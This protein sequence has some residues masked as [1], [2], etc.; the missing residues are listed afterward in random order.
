MADS[1]FDNRYR[2]D[3]IYPRGR[4][5]ETLRAVDTAQNDR[6]V[7]IKRPAPN[8]APPIRAGQEV[9]ILNERK[10]LLRLAGHA[11]LTAFIDAGQF[12]VGGMPHQYIVMERA[13]G[14][15]IAD[16]VIERARQGERLPLLE[17]LVIVDS[18]LDLLQAAHSR[19]IVYNDVDAKHLFW[20]RD[21]YRLKVIDWGNA[22]FLEGDD[23]TPQGISRQTDVFQVAELL[24]FMLCGGRRAEIPRDADAEFVLDFGEDAERISP[25]LQAI[26]SKAAHPNARLRYRSIDD[27][28]RALAE[29]RAPLERERDAIVN[30]V[31]ERLRRDLSKTDLRGLVNMLE[32]VL[33]SDP[34]YPPARKALQET[35][36]R[37]RDLDVAADLDVVRI[38]MERDNWTRA[39]DVLHELRDQAGPQTAALIDLLLDYT[40]LVLDSGLPTTPVVVHD[41]VGLIFDGDVVHAAQ[42]LLTHDNPDDDGRKLQWLLAERISSR[43]PDVLLLRPNLY[44]LELALNTIEVEGINISEARALLA[45]TNDLLDGLPGS[46]T[47]DLSEL[48][49]SYRAVVDRLSTLNKLL[50]TVIVQQQLPNRKLPLTALDRAINAAMTLADNM[51]VIGKQAASSPRDALVALDT[52]RLIDPT[53]PLWRFISDMLDSLYERLQTYQTYVPA[54]D[55]SDLEAWLVNAHTALAPYLD[56]MFD[57]M[58]A[59][60]IEGLTIARQSWA[61]YA[62]AT[63]SGNRIGAISSL[64]QAS[65]AVGTVS[66]T[67]AG[68]LNQLRSVVDG[69]HYVERHAIFGGLGRALADGWEAFDRGRLPDAE[70]LGQQALE[71]ARSEMERGASRRLFDLAGLVRD[72]VERSG[73]SSARRTQA[74][75]ETVES[76]YS[77]EELDQRD[78]FATQMPSRETYLRAMQKGLIEQYQRSS[79]AALRLF[80][81]NAVLLGTLEAHDGNLDDARFW[82]DVAVRSMGDA[83][84]RHI[85]ARTLG[86]FIERRK[87]ILAGVELLNQITSAQAIKN[88]ESTRR[89]LEENPQAK[90]LAAGI[91]SLREVELALRDWAD[92]EFRAAGLKLENAIN[93]LSDLEQSVEMTLTPYRTWLLEL[94]AASA[95]LHTYARQM[96]QTIE[97]RPSEPPQELYEAH[98]RPVDVTTRLLGESYAAQLRVWYET[99][100]AFLQAYT[101]QSVRRSVRLERFNELFRA[102]FIDR[103]PAY[104]LY[105]HWYDLTENAPEFPAPPTSDPTPRL[106]DEEDVIEADDFQP[107][108]RMYQPVDDADHKPASVTGTIRRRLPIGRIAVAAALALVGVLVVVVLTMQNGG[109]DDPFSNVPVTL[110]DTP[111][112]VASGATDVASV[113]VDMT[114]EVT[115]EVRP[116]NTPP[117][118]RTITPATPTERP[119]NTDTPTE[120]VVVDPPTAAPTA[121]PTDEPPSETPTLTNTATATHTPTMTHTPTLPASGLQGWQEL[122]ELP[123]RMEQLPW[124]PEHF[125]LMPPGNLWRLGMGPESEGG[126]L[127]IV[128]PSDALDVFYGNDAPARIRRTEARLSLATYL[129]SPDQNVY[130]GIM[131]QGIDDPTQRAGLYIEVYNLN[132][133]NLYLRTN[134]PEPV[135]VRQLSVNAVDVRVR[136]ERD[137]ATGAVTIFFDDRQIGE[138]IPFVAPEAAVEPVLFVKNGGVIINV[139][140]W[141][142]GLR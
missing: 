36:D 121:T 84:A 128:F 74:A 109:D 14:V 51:H 71:I 142:I 66:P 111:E 38:Y 18:L 141:R 112:S 46:E 75:L 72:W 43:V 134:A 29:H 117:A 89:Q 100:T 6:R 26:V 110:S 24:Y 44:R 139:S 133:L 3:W 81:F 124:D 59:G 82:Q 103:H 116:S 31:A 40:M 98:R 104:A 33:N 95:E 76:L 120:E 107:F 27:L 67:L 8:D 132:I 60:M 12:F 93:A 45:E 136:L 42:S 62:Q 73:V 137:A 16:E 129:P 57:E 65:D 28:R 92:G 1:L 69:S 50:S 55:G 83:G 77:A 47:L 115:A 15:I 125:S 49:D 140:S 20:D 13:D 85:L 61:N 108:E 30:R 131:L 78:H 123:A 10:A 5:G 88:L 23:V 86:D 127:D 87:D 53:S 17:M 25:T 113:M 35:T 99:Y 119:T 90:A 64:A 58:L 106:Q 9:S 34:G 126:E 97:R 22:I 130:F 41:A 114:D 94:Q 70:R 19:D 96:R 138:P 80:F 135:H 7:V 21:N 48:R 91:H 101:D 54:A 11:V 105:R 32:P 56:R 4:S 122:L 79:T 118:P 63:I 2:Y 39:A 68:W 52:S 102:M 37:L